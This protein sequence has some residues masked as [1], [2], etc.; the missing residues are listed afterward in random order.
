MSRIVVLGDLNLDVCGDGVSDPRPGY[1]V[2]GSVRANAGGSAGTFARVAA[3]LGADVTFFGAVG[4]DIVGDLLERSL[5]AAGAEAHL[6][7]GASPSG[8]VVAVRRGNERSM[9]CSRGA[10][11][12]L[13]AGW[14]ADGWPPSVDHLHVS[15]Y[16]FLAE[17]PR[18]AARKGIALAGGCGASVSLN[19]PPANL[20][21]AFGVDRFRPF[22][23]GV[24]WLFANQGEGELLAGTPATDDTVR[25]L[26][27]QYEAGALTLGAQG[28]IAWRDGRV[29]RRG[30]EA[31]LDVNPTGAGDAYAAGFVVALLGGGALG[32]VHRAASRAA[33]DY[34][35]LR[36][37]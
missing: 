19:L 15:G 37:A 7:R 4:R 35:C 24:D 14:V 13:D 22:L 25:V 6:A 28:A 17:G 29:D 9:I 27:R 31:V 18:A 10:N 16:S 36:G 20:L 8:A 32:A 21:A 11:D 34:L 33:F 26:A 5:V 12:D 1:E 2:R 30:P 3:G 23:Q